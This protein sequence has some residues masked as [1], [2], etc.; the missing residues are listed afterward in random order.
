MMPLWVLAREWGTEGM[1]RMQPAAWGK[2][3]LNKLTL[4]GLLGV[5]LLGEEGAQATP[6]NYD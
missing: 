1:W 2:A 6:I 5:R 4:C 3:T